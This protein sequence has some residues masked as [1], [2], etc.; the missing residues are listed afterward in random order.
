MALRPKGA[1]RPEPAPDGFR[2][3]QLI[4]AATFPEDV[5]RQPGERLTVPENIADAWETR[6]IAMAID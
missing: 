4:Y 6:G 1:A 3:V 2:I 5:K